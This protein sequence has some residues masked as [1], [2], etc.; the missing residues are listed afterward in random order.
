MGSGSGEQFE[1]D[2][3]AVAEEVFIENGRISTNVDRE[4]V[5]QA[6]AKH[7][8]LSERDAERA[9]DV[10]IQEYQQMQPRLQQ[11]KLRAEE[12]GQQVA[13]TVSKA[14]IWA[15]V[16]L[17]LGVITAAIGGSLGKPSVRETTRTVRT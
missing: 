4:E 7:S 6:V 16:A 3:M 8:S 2:L 1:I 10:I 15:F 9:T 12:T 5:E 14:S 17:V 11:L 13:E